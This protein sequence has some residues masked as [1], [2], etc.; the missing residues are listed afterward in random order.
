MK[1][2]D[3]DIR[4]I[5][6]RGFYQRKDFIKTPTIVVDEMDICAGRSRI[7]IA[8]INGKMHGYEIKSK[9]D[10]LERLPRQVEDYNKIFD[11]MT[12]VVFENHLDKIYE[13]IP[14]W[15]TVKSVKEKNSKI[16]I[17]TIRKGQINKNI[18]VDSLILLLWR[19][20][21]INALMM[22]TDIRKGYKSK[23]RKQLGELLTAHIS[24]DQIPLIVREQLKVREPWKSV[25]IQQQDGDCKR[26][27][28]N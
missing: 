7:D 21:M 23:T 26:M 14:S 5:L 17:T 28:P 25:A 19:D 6:Y 2:Y 15:W 11:T 20:E 16:V 24:H 3:S 1:I 8:V 22:Y 9:Q 4:K 13:L 27:L 10:N 12:L 18:D